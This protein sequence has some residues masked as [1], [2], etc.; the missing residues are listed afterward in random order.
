M[1]SLRANIQVQPQEIYTSSSTQGAD[2]GAL[3]TTGDGRYFRYAKAGATA[4]VPGQVYQGPA[5]SNANWSPVGGLGVGQ[6]QATGQSSFTVSASITLAA[7][8]LAGGLMSV[9]VTPGQGYSYKVKS[10]SAVS[11]ATGAVITLEDPLVTNL[12]VASR[13]VFYP[14]VYN[15]IVVV[16]TTPTAPIVGVAIY[17]VTAA[18]FGWVQSRGL[19]SVLIGATAAPGQQ[20]ASNGLNG[21]TGAV[22]P[23]TGSYGLVGMAVAT[24]NLGEYDLI[25]LQID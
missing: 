5:N 7:N 12:S 4:L 25:Q 21:T 23:A 17:P 22:A 2:L 15:G 1:S 18:Q 6:A 16:G 24:A 14:N 8:D 9:A 11:A 19:A 20:V 3:A 10:N 13:V